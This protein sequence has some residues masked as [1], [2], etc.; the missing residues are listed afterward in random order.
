MLRP[1]ARSSPRRR[2]WRLVQASFLSSYQDFRQQAGTARFTS[3]V[4][5]GYPDGD[6][7]PIVPPLSQDGTVEVSAITASTAAN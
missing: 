6:T 3:I 1:R 4:A 7:S 5:A 2:S